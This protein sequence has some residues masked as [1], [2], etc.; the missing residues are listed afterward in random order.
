MLILA[1]PLGLALGAAAT[2]LSRRSSSIPFLSSDGSGI[3]VFEV[4]RILPVP[5][6]P[7]TMI[8]IFTFAGLLDKVWTDVTGK[9]GPMPIQA[10]EI[11]LAQA[12][13][14]GSGY[15]TF[16]N[17]NA[18][19]YQCGGT[20]QG[21]SYYD[22]IPH[23]DSRPDPNGGPNIKYTTTFRSYKDGTTPD[24]KSRSAREAGAYDFLRSITVKPFPAIDQL[25]SGDLL[26]YAR[27]Q[28]IN[29]YFEGFNLSPEGRAAYKS[30]IDRVI[31]AGVPLRKK[32]ETPEIVAGRIV[33]YASSMA[34]SLPAIVAALGEKQATS[35]VPPDLT[36]RW[37]PKYQSK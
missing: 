22:C 33:F 6:N 28:L 36:I 27:Q 30:S 31:A 16:M 13:A 34:R 9:P 4:A 7:Q 20:Q 1:F 14:E 2:A 11:V 8:K 25:M 18:G 26:G 17:G 10:K 12:G 23:E 21:T 3:E 29:H 24:G 15:G 5:S 35:R 32:G 37:D 19:S